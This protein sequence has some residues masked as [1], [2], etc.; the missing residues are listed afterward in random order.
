MVGFTD[1][2]TAWRSHKPTSVF[3]NKESRLT[4]SYG[5]AQKILDF[6]TLTRVIEPVNIGYVQSAYGFLVVIIRKL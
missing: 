1:K 3:Q 6:E 2:Q 4:S 5:K